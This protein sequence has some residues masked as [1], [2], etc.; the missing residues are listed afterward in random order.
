MAARILET[1][2]AEGFGSYR[3]EWAPAGPSLERVSHAADG[4][5]VPGFVDIHC[6]GAF[7]IDLMSAPVADIEH[8]CTRLEREGY[9]VFLPTTVTASAPEILNFLNRMPE[10]AMIPGIHM[11]GPFISPKYPGAQPPSAIVDPPHRPSEWDEVLDHPRLKLVTLAPERPNAPDLIL[12]L[13]KRGVVVSMG[14]TDATYDEAR[15]GFEFGA[16]H[17]THTYNAM[18]ALHHREAGMVGYALLNVGL[19]CEL[20][21][22]RLHVCFEAAKLLIQHKGMDGVIGISDSTMATGMPPGQTITMWGLE[23][24]TGKNEVRLADSGAL[25]GSA[26]TL[27]DVFLNLW[28]DFGPE[29][30]IRACSLNPRKAIGHLA[31]PR[32]WLEFDRDC[33]LREVHHVGA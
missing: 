19:K 17:L 32:L 5:L 16:T 11:E 23:C 10:S 33:N 2:G 20:I 15:Q 8:L 7:G 12:R 14:H 13:Q 4:L 21:Y 27:R 25:A 18:R 9:D 1:I 26:V 31:P 24:I 6:H 30:A 3:F 28:E 22:D 29:L